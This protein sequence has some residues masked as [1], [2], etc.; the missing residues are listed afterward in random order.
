MIWRSEDERKRVVKR[1]V[2][3]QSQQGGISDVAGRS[4][5]YERSLGRGDVTLSFH[6]L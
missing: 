6:F 3:V 2:L 4:A 1:R 5:Q